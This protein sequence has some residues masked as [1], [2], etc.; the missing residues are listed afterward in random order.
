MPA[1]NAPE[2]T[3]AD[4]RRRFRTTL[5]RVMVVQVVAVLLLWVL[6]ARYGL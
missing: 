4:N 6:Q 2:P 5:I 3:A 1:P